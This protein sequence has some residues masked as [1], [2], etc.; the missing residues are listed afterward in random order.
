MT[1]GAANA[2]GSAVPLIAVSGLNVRFPVGGGWLTVVRDVNMSIRRGSTVGIVGES[3]SGKTVTSRGIVG[4]LPKLARV[5]GSVRLNGEEVLH[6][7]DR[8]WREHRRNGDFAMVFQ[9]AARALN[10]TMRVG[11]Q[12]AE[13]VRMRRA[14]SAGDAQRDAIGLLDMVRLPD[15]RHRALDFPH[16]L[17]GGMRQRVMIAIALAGQPKL[18][19]ADEATSAL[20]VTTQSQIMDLMTSLQSELGL[21][22]MLITHDIGL[23]TAYTDEIIVMY[24]GSVVECGPSADLAESPRMPYTRALFDAIPDPSRPRSL[25][26]VVA[27]RPPQPGALPEGCAFSERCPSVTEACK[28]KRPELVEDASGHAWACLH[29]QPPSRAKATCSAPSS[30]GQ[31]TAPAASD[32]PEPLLKV[33][34]LVQQFTLRRNAAVIQAVS[35]VSFDLFPGETLALVGESGSGKSTLARSLL[36]APPPAT[37]EIR[38]EGTDLMTAG[39]EELRE[40]RRKMQMVYQDPFGSLDP[41]WR[42]RAIVEE[43][44][45]SYGLGG[46][47]ER[48]R[49]VDELLNQVGLDPKA[50]AGRH[51]RQLSGGQCQRVAIARAL[52]ASPAIVICDEA[53]SSLD[54]L[55]QAQVLNLLERLRRE[56]RIA[57]LFIA[58]DLSLVQQISDRVAVMYMGKIVELASAAALYRQP[59]HHYTAA[60]LAAVPGARSGE[61]PAPAVSGEVPSPMNPPS[62]CRFR[63]RCPRAADR[64]A[65]EEPRLRTVA[66]GQAVACHFPLATV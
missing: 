61:S 48:R 56:L 26:P 41:T 31:D 40:I 50:Y 9:D 63:T 23:A 19:I 45:I 25:L 27:A 5:S 24:A 22:L 38:V 65:A 62:G 58:H 49:R 64:C 57:Y 35:D 39:R 53:V 17:S 13:A 52:A 33:R 47:P 30:A 14:V 1:E 21:T 2:N 32:A 15:A 34:S 12:V 11:A 37:G 28:V 36:R 43:P 51:P 66:P 18:L 60:L 55:V 16:Q 3:G 29:P 59:R 46:K 20:D 10:P 42:V 54:V 7:S 6:S 4:L 44:L 8:E